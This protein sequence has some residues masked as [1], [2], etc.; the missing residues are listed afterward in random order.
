MSE[1]NTPIQRL[2]GLTL[3]STTDGTSFNI[4]SAGDGDVTLAPENPNAT[5]DGPNN[6]RTLSLKSLDLNLKRGEYYFPDPDEQRQFRD[7][8]DD[9]TN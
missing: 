8:V 4:E 6:K 1:N 5:P 7:A 2:R 3:N 9:L